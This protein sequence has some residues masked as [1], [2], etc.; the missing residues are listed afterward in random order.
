VSGAWLSV[1][2]IGE[3]GYDR[4]APEARALVDNAEVLI[5]GARHLAMV[6]ESNRAVRE[7]WASPLSATIEHLRDLAGRRVCVLATGDPMSFGIGVTLA[8]EFPPGEMIVIPA[9]GAFSLAAAR[10]GWSLADVDC[11]TL[12]G[13]PLDLL[14]RHVRPDARL[15]ILANDGNSAEQVARLLT[16]RGYGGSAVSV[17]EHMGGEDEARLDGVARSWEVGRTDDLCTIAVTCIADDGTEALSCQ[18][19]LP[20]DVFEHDGQLTKREVRAATLAALVPLPRALLWDVGAGCGSVAIEWM[21]AG[22]RAIAIERSPKRI[23][24]IE[25]NA[26]QLGTPL[27]DV[28]R[29]RA[30]DVLHGLDR[31]DA[32]FIGGGI[33]TPDLAEQCWE[34]L[35]PGGRLVANVV[36]AEGERR[37]LDLFERLGGGLTRLAVSR[38]T[39]VGPLHGWRPLMTVTQ[40]AAG[41]PR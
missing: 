6:P 9:P 32:V 19:G 18:P 15:L 33:G 16:E 38:L 20:D 1:V 11:L 40:W 24:L 34:S 27:L 13:R 22:G 12:H 37:V 3:D 7:R 39:P 25:R 14:N 26:A 41:K 17:L 21:R 10:L 31:P 36:T 5:G 8:R 30:P 35:K 4:L 29:G 23:A 28:V 2:G